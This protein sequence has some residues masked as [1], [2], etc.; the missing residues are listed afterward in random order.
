MLAGLAGFTAIGVSF[1]DVWSAETF[2]TLDTVMLGELALAGTPASEPATNVA[3]ANA[4]LVGLIDPPSGLVDDVSEAGVRA[5]GQ[6]VV[7]GSGAGV[8]TGRAVRG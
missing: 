1:C 8:G 6:R 3:T 7:A 4:A 5:P 2:T